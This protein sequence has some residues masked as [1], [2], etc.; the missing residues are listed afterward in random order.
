MH[1]RSQDGRHASAYHAHVCFQSSPEPYVVVI[2]GCIAEITD[3]SQVLQSDAAASSDKDSDKEGEYYSDF[4][5]CVPDL[6]LHEL[7]DREEEDNKVEE[8][9]NTSINVGG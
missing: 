3:L 7:R 1:E 5:S 2:V 8:D 9:V 4:T 6:K